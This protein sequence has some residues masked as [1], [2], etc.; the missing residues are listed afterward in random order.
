M[1]QWTRVSRAQPCQVCGH[2]DWCGRS[3][4]M[5]RCMRVTEPPPG[6][7]VV[8]R[9]DDGGVV[10]EPTDCVLSMD[11]KYPSH[12]ASQTTG[13]RWEA[14]SEQFVANLT[15][16]LLTSLAKELGVAECAL[17][18]LRIGWDPDHNAY[19]CPERNGAGRVIGIALRYPNGRKGFVKGGRRGLT[20]GGKL[21]DQPDPVLVVEGPSD[22]AAAQTLGLT[23]VGRPSNS[24]GVEFLADL[25]KGREVIILAENDTKPDGRCPGR[26]GALAVTQ[27]L[28]GLWRR[29]VKWACLPAD[30]K[31]FREFLSR[32]G[33]DLQDTDGLRA[34][35]ESL[36]AAIVRTAQEVQPGRGREPVLVRMSTV[37]P[38]E[39]D[40]LWRDRIPLGKLSIIAGDPGLGKSF[41]TLDLA[42][43]VSTG[44]PFP[45]ET[46]SRA[47]ASAVLLSAEDGLADTIRPRLDAAGADPTKIHALR[48]IRSRDASSVSPFSLAEDLA[49]LE[50]VLVSHP[51][52][53]LVVID[54]ISAYI[55]SINT[56]RDA[57]IRQVLAPLAELA[58]RYRVAVLAVVHLNKNQSTK[59]LYRGNGSIGLVAAARCVWLVAEDLDD[60]DLRM[61]LPLKNNLVPRPSGLAYRLIQGRVRWESG[62][63]EIDADTVLA[64]EAQSHGRL[65]ERDEAK[66]WL[67]HLLTDG[68]VRAS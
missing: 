14:L 22:V 53:H 65:T 55:G 26:D 60:R 3:G 23:A 66:E 49:V 42:A 30:A 10:F 48:G 12:E 20:Y 9:C 41:I 24:G 32:T 6:W 67:L 39:V 13:T 56:H 31:D 5:V 16:S 21:S 35:G 40:W 33:I 62:P 34:A 43:R 58:E 61:V 17:R 54:P 25:L 4:S 44:S 50:Q 51:D 1:N 46:T 57:A 63:V 52:V 18:E 11:R 28:A 27:R 7:R 29:S 38:E 59:A 47:P 2:E 36:L 8:K 37:K 64:S 68:P 15:P 45:G 19:T